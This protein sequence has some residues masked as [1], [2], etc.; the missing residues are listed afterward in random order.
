MRPEH[1]RDKFEAVKERALI[2][3]NTS[4]AY[5]DMLRI[6]NLI[7]ACESKDGAHPTE[8]KVS[9]LHEATDLINDV[10]LRLMKEQY[11]CR[12]SK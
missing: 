4:V 8:A 12:R 11:K 6:K 10:E 2:L 5:L 1:Y 7:K 3:E 9:Y